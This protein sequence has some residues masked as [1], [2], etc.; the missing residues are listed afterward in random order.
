MMMMSAELENTQLNKHA[1]KQ[2]RKILNIVTFVS[3]I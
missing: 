2:R 3:F 1:Y